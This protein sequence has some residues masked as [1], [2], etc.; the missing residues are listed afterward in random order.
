MPNWCYNNVTFEHSNPDMIVALINAAKEDKLFGAFVPM[1]D[2]IRG[3]T[4]PSTP[5]ATLL[6]KYGHSDWYSWSLDNWGTKWE[7]RVDE[8]NEYDEDSS[9]VHIYFE[10]AWSP[11]IAFF[12]K[13]EDLG[14]VIDATYTE[15]GMGFVGIYR[16]GEDQCI[17]MG[18]LY[19]HENAEDM[20]AEVED[21]D[22]RELVKE[23]YDS[24]LFI[25]EQYKN[26]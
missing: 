2:E 6:E 15:E 13:M 18:E 23:E 8:V 4:S 7:A 16:N 22:L 5:N 10:T 25:N 9:S 3:S 14:F 19:N 24:W 26:D 20:I 1:P 12:K 11:P 21:E 17:D